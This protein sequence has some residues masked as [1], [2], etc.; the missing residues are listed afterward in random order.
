VCIWRTRDQ[1]HCTGQMTGFITYY[2]LGAKFQNWD[3]RQA[4]VFRNMVMDFSELELYW[5]DEMPGWFNWQ[6]SWLLINW[7]TVR[8][9]DEAITTQQLN[10]GCASHQGRAKVKR[11]RIDSMI[12]WYRKWHCPPKDLATVRNNE[13]SK[14]AN[15][16]RPFHC[17]FSYFEFKIRVIGCLNESMRMK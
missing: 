10:T 8:L 7:F 13:C 17:L 1:L 12:K 5:T 9:P 14:K 4:M 2:W 16:K 3:Y 11:L 15:K 6:R